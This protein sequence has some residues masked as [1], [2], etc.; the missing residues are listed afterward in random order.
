MFS[1]LLASTVNSCSTDEHS[2]KSSTY[3]S[4]LDCK[5][6]II[7][8]IPIRMFSTGTRK[9]HFLVTRSEAV[10]QL[11][12]WLIWYLVLSISLFCQLSMSIYFQATS[13]PS[14]DTAIASPGGHS[15]YLLPLSPVALLSHVA[16]HMPSPK[17][18][19]CKG[20]ELTITGLD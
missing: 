19:P 13:P 17:P 20:N 11:P 3:L 18:I 16:H 2:R 9:I 7:M 15:L 14:Q 8:P 1:I 10:R 4:V 5:L 12:C 6:A